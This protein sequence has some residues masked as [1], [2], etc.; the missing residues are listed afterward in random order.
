MKKTLLLSIVALLS[1]ACGSPGG[2]DDI[3]G[4]WQLTAGTVDGEEIP[5]LDSHPITMTLEDDQVSGTASCN[6]YGG[7]FELSGSEITFSS[8]IMTEM[9]CSPEETMQAEAMFAT[10]MTRVETVAMDG[11]FTLTG[12]GVELVFDVVEPGS[13]GP[14]V[15]ADIQGSW[16]LTA[17]TVDGEEIPILDTHPIT[18][19]L[20]DDQVS[21]T[22]SC[23]GYGGTFELSGSEVTFSGL[24]MTEMACSPEETMQAEAMFGEAITLVETVALDGQLTLTGEAVELV[25][26]HLEPVP[27]SELTN[28]VWVLDSL[29]SGDS[30]SS[31]GGERATLE[32]FTDGSVLGSTGCRLLT[33]EY[34]A[35]GAELTITNLSAEG[36]CDPELT[37]QDGHVISVLEGPLMVEIEGASLVLTARG[38]EGLGYVADISAELPPPDTGENGCT[39][40][41]DLA[42]EGEPSETLH[43]WVSNQS[44]EVD[45][46]SIEIYIDDQPVVCDDFYVEGQ[47]NW[48][49]FDLTME[50]GEHTLHAVRID[51][52]AELTETFELD[53]ERWAVVDFWFYPEDGPEEFAFSIHDA[54][55][56]FA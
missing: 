15:D 31:V 28:T 32:F 30:V 49:L 17:G 29:I 26:E 45:P 3:Q 20:E 24:A 40:V 9:A 13:D 10:A 16:Q 5:I 33:G 36:E 4:S 39:P 38:E 43:L 22:A 8:I 12:E 25:F 48:I 6:G 41:T 51:G 7:T 35:N 42:G 23:N 19:T 21:G 27:D 52:T 54:P 2:T 53:H 18:M 47:H 44:F 55:V 11:E 34:I 50:P 1:V 14:P 46:A 37:D 56:A